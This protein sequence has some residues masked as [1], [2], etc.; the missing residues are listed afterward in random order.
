MHSARTAQIPCPR[1]FG[2]SAKPAPSAAFYVM[3]DGC[4]TTKAAESS[5]SL[6]FACRQQGYTFW[7][8]TW[9]WNLEGLQYH[10]CIRWL[11]FCLLLPTAHLVR[12]LMQLDINLMAY[13]PISKYES[14]YE[15]WWDAPS[16]RCGRNGVLSS[17]ASRLH[18]AD[19]TSARPD[20]SRH[21]CYSVV[22]TYGRLLNV[23]YIYLPWPQW[24][25][26]EQLATSKEFEREL[27]FSQ[28]CFET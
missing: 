2:G 5:N 7:A 26:Q 27:T 14:T 16:L 22:G 19:K 13:H 24:L 28:S 11:S 15:N 17:L 23:T 10:T 3:L 20:F 4:P 8:A 18:K 12:L 21:V 1:F 6:A 9:T 25:T